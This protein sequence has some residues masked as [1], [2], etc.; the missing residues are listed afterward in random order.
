MEREIV[1]LRNQLANQQAL[2][3][4]LA[5]TH[6]SQ[7]SL[8]PTTAAHGIPVPQISHS[9]LDQ[10]MGSQDAVASLLDLKSGG[11][12]GFGR[13]PGPDGKPLRRLEAVVLTHTQVDELFKM[14]GNHSGCPCTCSLLLASSIS[15]TRCSLFLILSVQPTSIS[16]SARSYFGL[17]YP[18]LRDT[19]SLLRSHF[20]RLRQVSHTCCGRISP[21]YHRV[22]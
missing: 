4:P 8:G 16:R 3:S 13:S 10:Y 11:E 22:T 6:A 2:S 7:H 21:M 14:Y 9:P 17:S 1:E 5:Q 12:R 19:T 20:Q 18:L 15:I